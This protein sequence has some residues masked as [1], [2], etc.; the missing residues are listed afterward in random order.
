MSTGS[1]P[2]PVRLWLSDSKGRDLIQLQHDWFARNWRKLGDGDEYPRY[3][4]SI[5]QAFADDLSALVG[6]FERREWRMVPTQCEVTYINHIKPTGFWADHGDAATVF[7]RLRPLS[8]SDSRAEAL[9]FKA[10]YL[11]RD[12]SMSGAPIGRLHAQVESAFSDR[13]EPL[14]V[15]NLTARGAPFDAPGID[16]VLHFLDRGREWVVSTFTDWTTEEAHKAWRR[17]Q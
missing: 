3:E 13:G 9:S 4:R 7:S 5:R 17:V 12:S 2:P 8:M 14:F 10:S 1:G 11:M 6:Q 15:F 16:G